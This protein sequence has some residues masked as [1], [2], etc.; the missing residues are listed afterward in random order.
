MVILALCLLILFFPVTYR[1]KG[2]V[3]G[4]NYVV[5]LHCGWLFHLVHF[6]GRFT[7]E[8]KIAKLQI[9]GIP[10]NL[11]KDKSDSQKE[12]KN[13]GR[14]KKDNISSKEREDIKADNYSKDK[15][16]NDQKIKKSKQKQQENIVQSKEPDKSTKKEKTVYN[17]VKELFEKI[18]AFFK[19]MKEKIKNAFRNVEDAYNK[20]KEA[21]AF[22]T[23]NTTKEAY[24]YGKKIIIK[25]VK[26]IFPSKIR[27]NIH[28]GFDEPDKTGQM[29]GYLGMAFSAFHMNVKHVS[30]IPSFNKK[31]LEGNIKIKGHFLV[32]ILLIDGLRFY[33]KKEIHDIIK[34]FS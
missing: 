22:I 30:V 28:F 26:H 34:K 19:N 14:R 11:L 13:K 2:S 4:K 31:V 10:I 20:V 18:Y 33:F 6:K 21:K 7:K 17:K 32:G 12:K 1:A 23:A 16:V 5:D 25:V 8:D 27:A 24:Q 9:V 3:N 15:L 29:L